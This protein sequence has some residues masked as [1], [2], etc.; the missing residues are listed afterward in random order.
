M[1]T[2]KQGLIYLGL[3]IIVIGTFGYVGG[4]ESTQLTISTLT[5]QSLAVTSLPDKIDPT[6]A[7][8]GNVSVIIEFSGAISKL[9][10]YPLA[11]QPLEIVGFVP[12]A[13]VPIELIYQGKKSWAVSGTVNATALPDI[14]ADPNVINIW[15]D[16]RIYLYNTC[17]PIDCDVSTGYSYTLDGA[18]EALKVDQVWANGTTGDGIVVAIADTGVNK[19]HPELTGRVVDGWAPENYTWGN[20]TDVH[21]TMTAAIV[22]GST[23]NGGKYNG[24]A[25]EAE[26]YDVMIMPKGEGYASDTLDGYDWIIDHYSTDGTPQIVSNSW[27]C[28]GPCSLD[29]PEHPVT[30]KILQAIDRGIAV[31]FAQGNCGRTCPSKFCWDFRAHLPQGLDK[32]IAVGAVNPAL[33]YVG[34]STEGPS[35]IGILKP[36]VM[37]ITHFMGALGSGYGLNTGTSSSAPSIAGVIALL[38]QANPE[39]TPAEVKK[40]L[41]ESATDMCDA[42]FD[43]WTGYGVVDAYDAYV[44]A[45]AFPSRRNPWGYGALSGVAMCGVGLIIPKPKGKRFWT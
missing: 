29:N 20:D 16:E 37:G 26:I 9:R 12:I 45:I 22:A 11:I 3:F 28:Y 18:G 21:G 42:G 31:V 23:I 34:Y 1:V 38:K 27:G 13:I 44:G 19:N 6:L 43:K 30:K 7:K 15:K 35:V 8:V 17:F 36:D 41:E 2:L 25:P 33:N 4:I 14:A 24:M 10:I 39:L 40:I 32:V 5:I